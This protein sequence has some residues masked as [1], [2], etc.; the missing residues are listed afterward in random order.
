MHNINAS[1]TKY[2]ISLMDYRD[3][4]SHIIIVNKYA[5]SIGLSVYNNLIIL[6]KHVTFIRRHDFYFIIIENIHILFA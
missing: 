1:L 2:L 3:D 6:C 5:K 4:I